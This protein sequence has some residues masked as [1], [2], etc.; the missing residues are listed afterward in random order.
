MVILCS[1][2]R[3]QTVLRTVKKKTRSKLQGEKHKR[4]KENEL[5][6]PDTSYGRRHKKDKTT[7]NNKS[8]RQN[9][10]QEG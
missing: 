2:A 5:P 6:K 3:S 4:E 7:T 10:V 8:V 9:V 1:A